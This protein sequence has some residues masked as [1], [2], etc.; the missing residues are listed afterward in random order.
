MNSGAQTRIIV[1]G[2]SITNLPQSFTRQDRPHSGN[3]SLRG[4]PNPDQRVGDR[5]HSP[6]HQPP[7]CHVVALVIDLIGHRIQPIR[8]ITARVS[9]RPIRLRQ[10]ITQK[11][12]QGLDRGVRRQME[13]PSLRQVIL[14]TKPLRQTPQDTGR[15]TALHRAPSPG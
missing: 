4:N 9:Q 12:L 14:R 3:Q 6:D 15:I 13:Y 10:I 8:Q 2:G 1:A 5:H 11:I 7:A